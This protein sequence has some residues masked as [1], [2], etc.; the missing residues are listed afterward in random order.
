[1]CRTA[2]MT[3][4][5]LVTAGCS[6]QVESRKGDA[7]TAD[8][9]DAAKQTVDAAKKHTTSERLMRDAAIEYAAERS[10]REAKEGPVLRWDTSK[11]PVRR[12]VVKRGDV[13]LYDGPIVG[14]IWERFEGEYEPSWRSRLEWNDGHR[15]Q[16]VVYNTDVSYTIMPTPAK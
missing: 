15:S 7:G 4:L 10:E 11:P 6:Q 8:T 16:S 13:L 12:I 14:T 5:I 1:M 2:V 9:V 3:A